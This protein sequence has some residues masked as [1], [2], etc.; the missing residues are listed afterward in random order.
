MREVGHDRLAISARVSKFNIFN[1]LIFNINKD[2][3][4]FSYI[5]KEFGSCEA[6]LS[7][8]SFAWHGSLEDISAQIIDV[9][10]IR[11]GGFSVR[12]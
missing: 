7:T 10:D 12:N 6:F 11:I 2:S 4:F 1:L 9:T 5:F 8:F 3:I